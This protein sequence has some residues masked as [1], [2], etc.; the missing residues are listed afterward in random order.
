[1]SAKDVVTE[2]VKEVRLEMAKISWPTRDELMD[3]TRLVIITIILVSA[4]VGVVDLILGFSVG[5]LFH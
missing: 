3:S 1:M 4:F 5:L 2:Y